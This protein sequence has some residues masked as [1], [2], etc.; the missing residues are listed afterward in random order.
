ME[1]EAPLIVIVPSP[2]MGHLIPLVEFAKVLVSRFHFSVS[3]LLPTTAQP[4]KAQTTLLNSLPSSVSHNF[5]PTVDPAHLP[6][7]VA[8]EVTISL[9]HAHSLSSIRAALGSLAQQAQVVAL[10]TDLFGTGLYTVARDLG[11][12]PYLYFTSTAMCLLFLFH[13]PKLDE[14]VS[15]EYRDMPEPLVLPGCVPLHGKD[16]VDPAQDRQDQ[17]YHV[18]LDH[19]K[20]Y[21]LAEGIFVN[22]FVDLEPGAIKTLQTEDPNVPPVYPVGPIIQSGLDD[23][24]H[25]SDCLKWL[26]RQPS[27]SVLF[28]SFGSGGTLSNEQL[29]ELAIG[30]EISGH[31][32]L[33]VVRSPNDHSSFGSFFS[34]QSQDDPFG[35]LPTG[36]VDRIK[37]RGLLVPS[38]APQIKVLSHGSTGGFLTHC[39]WNSTLESIVNGVPLIV[40]PLYAEQR[41]NAVMLNQGLKVA[42]RPNASQRGL[43]E[44]DEIARVVKELMDGDEGKKARYKMRELSDSAKRVTSENGESTK[45][46]SE[47]A[48]KWSQCKS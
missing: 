37:D 47:V 42:L 16:F 27:G 8:H 5:L 40:W 43:V 2:G 4:T 25:G 3:L 36:F 39:G 19:V 22:T 48:S 41:M 17:A 44:A 29:N 34:T 20:R 7:G 13:L 18:L 12:P 45:L 24:S 28:V 46:L 15:C 6:D 38:W 35:F 26:D 33:W 21:V 14:T 1:M 31:R 30:L 23:D 10:I 32:F 11:I 9:T